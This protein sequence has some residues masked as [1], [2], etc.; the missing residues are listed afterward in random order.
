M[1][2]YWDRFTHRRLGR[3]R[4]LTSTASI[5]AAA[6]FLAACGGG[7]DSSEGDVQAP[8]TGASGSGLDGATLT[9]VMDST[10][11]MVRGGVG[12][13]AHMTPANLD[14]HLANGPV[15]HGWHAY[16]QLFRVKEGYL[17]R[18][19][20]EF[21][22]E[23]AESFEFSDDRLQLTIRLKPGVLFAPQEPVNARPVDAEDVVFSWNRYLDRSSRRTALSNEHN[24]NAPVL[25]VSAPDSMTVVIDLSEPN[26][27]ILSGFAGS[28][29][30]T[31]YIVPREV[32]S[33]NIDL[34]TE[35]A[36]SGA[37]YLTEFEPGFRAHYV[38]NPGFAN[39]DDRELPYIDEVEYIQVP[40]YA[41]FLAQFKAGQVLDQFFGVHSD[42]ILPT[43][44]TLPVLELYNAGLARGQVRTMYGQAQGSPF[45]D[46]RVRQAV[47][48]V[49][50]RERFTQLAFRTARFE[51][52]GIPV[53]KLWDTAIPAGSPSAY[54]GWWIDP[55]SPEFGENALYY[56]RELAV[57]QQLLQAATGDESIEV[58]LHYAAPASGF[59][60][61]FYTR[62]DILIAMMEESGLFRIQRR[63]HD[64]ASEWNP[65]FRTNRGEFHGMGM[66]M[67]TNEMDP[68]ADLF[69][70]YH[71]AGSRYYGGDGE[72]DRLCRALVQEFDLE[73]RVE[74]AHELQRYEGK[75][76]FRPSS[77]S[78]STIRI[79]WPAERNRGVWRGNENRWHADIWLDRTLPPF[80]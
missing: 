50:D 42:D 26:A 29:P 58:E 49:W 76:Q 69:S 14:P 5:A 35:S 33:H 51:D 32:E 31:P 1:R 63:E 80:V 10:S 30:G 79:G 25:S 23:L 22:G 67:D 24:P 62:Q 56:L 34:E 75:A 44:E 47:S 52:V 3:R 6:A 57:A 7:D 39:V 4:V 66:E 2:S 19:S 65:N 16:S 54:E 46:E 9:P 11:Q 71:S 13:W 27:T 17:A 20:G 45:R 70:H 61:F 41:A 72:L 21:E 36:G 68:A 48:M 28:S 53:D 12:T 37:F 55:R 18:A 78:S 43:K 38:R 64:L 15:V 74:L 8:P 60:A 59:P 77:T 40:D 73:A